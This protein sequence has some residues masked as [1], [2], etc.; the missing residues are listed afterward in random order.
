MNVL[1]I[2]TS[3][4]NNS[5]SSS[6]VE[7]ILDGLAKTTSNFNIKNEDLSSVPFI[8]ENHISGTYS[9]ESDDFI[10]KLEWADT[11]VIGFP[12]WNFSIP[13]KLKAYCDLVARAGTT[14]KYT[15][16]GPVGLLENKKAYLAVSSGGTKVGSEIDYATT[17][18]VHFLGFIGIHDVE[19][20]AADQTNI[21][22][23]QSLLK[24]GQAVSELFK[25][26][27]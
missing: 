18:M 2:R 13:A 22:L 23:E 6:I 20:I 24:A 26:A 10:R 7:S 12:I 11:I 9:K 14:F 21:N 15:E 5:I 25:E 4:K 27:A 16:N 1:T 17:W 3:P 19:I 8:D